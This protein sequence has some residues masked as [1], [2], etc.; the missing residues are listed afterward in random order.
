M[1]YSKS[2]VNSRNLVKRWLHRSRLDASVKLLDVKRRSRILDYGCGSGELTRRISAA[3]P[4]TQIV[5]FDPAEDLFRQAQRR[6]ADC[7]NVLVSNS[8]DLLP[9]AF[10]RVACLEVLEHLPPVELEAALLDIRVALAADGQCLFTFPIEHGAMSLA[11]NVYRITTGG[12]PY[13]SLTSTA[14]AFFG[15]PV[16]RQPSASLNNCSYIYSHLGF[17]CRA[18]LST[19][20][21]VF[22]IEDV[23][24]LP[25]GTV[26]L[27]M[28]N[29]LAVVARPRHD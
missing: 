6:L 16:P 2:T 27:G 14:R 4:S 13:P 23:H 24:V 18:M 17:D 3:Y 19:I 15:L 12:D 29:G 1:D 9:G 20:A 28:G 26:T 11:K 22:A 25:L 8:L 7:T 21:N 5:A 10:D